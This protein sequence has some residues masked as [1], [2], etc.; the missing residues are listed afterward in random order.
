MLE[1]QELAATSEETISLE[2]AARK[3]QRNKRKE[4]IRM[5]KKCT[6]GKNIERNKTSPRW[7]IC[8]ITGR[9]TERIHHVIISDGKAPRRTTGDDHGTGRCHGYTEIFPNAI[10]EKRHI[11]GLG[12]Y[13]EALDGMQEFKRQADKMN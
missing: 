5:E 3:L 2:E 9:T 4:R 8:K 10:R 11:S 13:T 12:G 1:V 6:R 7:S